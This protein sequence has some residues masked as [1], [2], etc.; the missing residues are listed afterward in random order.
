MPM[1]TLWGIMGLDPLV[2]R[3]CSLPGMNARN[4]IAAFAVP[5]LA[6]APLL[7][8]AAE[9][10]GEREGAKERAEEVDTQFIFGFTAGADVGEL[11]EREIESETIGRLRKRDGSYT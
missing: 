11:G 10:G 4:W 3:G 7:G 8:R 6:L 5:V 9:R 1:G 2:T